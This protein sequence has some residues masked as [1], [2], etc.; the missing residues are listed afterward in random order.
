M[1]FFKT[2]EGRLH[3]GRLAGVLYL[4]GYLPGVLLDGLTANNVAR[5]T[6]T[7]GWWLSFC[8]KRPA[9]GTEDLL[10]SP[11]RLVGVILILSGLVGTFYVLAR[12]LRA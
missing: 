10:K 8:D 12:N 9:L 5:L 6:Y 7:A 4:I 1:T 11:H 3:A 2:S